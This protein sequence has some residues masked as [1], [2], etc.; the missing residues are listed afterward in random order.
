[1]ARPKMMLDANILIYIHKIKPPEV[2][3]RLR[4]FKHGE[5][6][7]SSIAWEEFVRNAKKV[8]PVSEIG[9]ENLLLINDLA[10]LERR[11]SAF[12]GV[13]IRDLI[14]VLAFDEKA[15]IVFERISAS[16]KTRKKLNDCRIAAHAISLGVPLVTHDAGFRQ[17]RDEG[18]VV[19]DWVQPQDEKGKATQ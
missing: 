17:Y 8:V 19:E 7:A 15:E 13:V 4:T 14:D 1:M 12:G 16:K 2:I 6:A 9:D 5:V 18:L 3:A 11:V 10:S